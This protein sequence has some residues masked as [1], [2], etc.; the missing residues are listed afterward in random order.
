V[1]A[2]AIIGMT[3]RFPA[4]PDLH[5]FWQNLREG[6]E[7]ISFFRSDEL[8][9][10][11]VDPDQ[12]TLPGFV[13][14]AGILEGIDL[15]DA[16][17][18]GFNPRDADMLDPQHR[19]FLECA[20]ESLEDAGCDPNRYDGLIGVFAGGSASSYATHLRDLRHE[21]AAD[22][23][24]IILGNDTAFLAT[25][26]AYKLNLRGP[27]VTVQSACSTSLVAVTLA[28]HSLLD[29]QCD[30]A[31]AGGVTIKVPHKRGYIYQEGGIS[32]PDGH[33]RAF[34]KQAQG[35]VGGNGVG[36]VVLK[37]LS[38][39]LA[40]RDAIR[41]VILGAAI[42][43]D[44]SRKVSFA[45]PSIDGQARV[46]A[47]AQA[48]AGVQPETISY[49]E[50][51]GTGTRLGDPIEI[52][53]LAHA[54]RGVGPGKT[55]AIGSVKTN[56]GH[57]DCAAGVAGLIKTVLAL[58][59]EQI[60]PSLHFRE[61]NPE[62]GF[63]ATPFFVNSN[64]RPWPRSTR[65]RRAG[66]NSFGVGGTNAHVLVEEAP[67]PREPSPPGRP[68]QLLTFSAQTPTALDEMTSRLAKHLRTVRD[69][70]LADIAYSL[71]VGRKW[72][73]HRRFVVC[74][75]AADAAAA[76][77][78]RDGGCVVTATADD[79]TSSAVFLFS[80]QGA[81]H[82]G[83][84]RELY[85]DENAFRD[86][87]DRC[88]ELLQPRLGLDLRE[89]L[90]P[91]LS[92]R[93][94]DGN[95]KLLKTCLAQP[96]LFVVE[97]ALARLWQ[98]WGVV[99]C[100]MIG[101][102]IGEYAAACVAG[103]FRLEDALMLVA[104]RGRLMQACPAGAMTVVPLAEDKVLS[105][106]DGDLAL[107]A[108]NGSAL[109]VVSGPLDAVIGLERRVR[110]DGLVCRRL[111]TS[112]AFHS[113]MMEP[114]LAPFRAELSRVPLAAPQVPMLSNVTGNWLEPE[115]ATDPDYWVEQLRRTV[116]FSDGLRRVLA[117]SNAAL[118]E[119]GPGGTLASLARLSNSSEGPRLILNSL[120]HR[121]DTQPSGRLFWSTLGR[122]W[123]AGHPI[124]WAAVHAHERRHRVRL[125][126]YP[127][128]RERYWVDTPDGAA[129]APAA[130]VAGR[131]TKVADIA[132]WFYAPS[133]TRTPL[134]ER[135]RLR[136]LQGLDAHCLVLSDGRELGAA[137][138]DR[139]EAEPMS[140]T[141]VTAGA[142]F[143]HGGG[144]H[145]E[146]DPA[147]REDYF[148]LV[149]ALR[150]ERRLPN[151]IVHLWGLEPPSSSATED[152]CFN[153]AQ[154]RGFYSIVWL[155]QALAQ[156]RVDQ[157]IAIDVFVSGLYSVCDGDPLVPERAPV[158]AA[159]RGVSQ[160]YPHLLCRTIDLQR[161]GSHQSGVERAEVVEALLS[162]IIQPPV[163]GAIAYRGRTR[164]SRSYV[165]M[166][167]AGANDVAG[168]VRPGGVYLITG[169]LGKIGL[170]LAR[171]LAGAFAAKLVLVGP[172][173][174]RASALWGAQLATR[175]DPEEVAQRVRAI[176]EIEAAGGEVLVVT[177]DLGDPAQ[178]RMA[179]ERARQRF[180]TLNGIIHGA[181]LTRPIGIRMLQDLDRAVCEAHFHAK[182]HSVLALRAAIGP[183]E[184]DFWV[185]LSS[186][187]S[188][189]GGLG[190]IPYAAANAFLDA[191]AECQS[192]RSEEAWISIDWDGW[193]LGKSGH[194]NAPPARELTIT[195][196]E[197]VEAFRRILQR[198]PELPVVVSTGD[199]FARIEQWVSA[200]SRGEA[201]AA[202]QVLHVRPPI[203]TSYMAPRDAL[204]RE[205]VDVWQQLFGLCS[206]GINDSF[207][208]LGGH[209]LL[210]TTLV[211]RMR[212]KGLHTDIQALLDAPTPAGLAAHIM[213]ANKRATNDTAI[214]VRSTNTGSPLFFTNDG[215]GQVIYVQALAPYI[216]GDISIYVVPDE[217]PDK[218][219]LRT[220]E[221]LASRLVR[222]IEAVQPKGPYR[223][224]GYSFGGVLAFEAATQ[225][226]GRDQHVEFLGLIDSNLRIP[227]NARA[228][229]L[230]ADATGVDANEG[231]LNEGLLMYIRQTSID[232]TGYE[233]RI[234]ELAASARTMDLEA[235][236]KKAEELSLVPDWLT[237]ELWRSAGA[238]LRVINK[239]FCEYFPHPS[240]LAVHL[241]TADAEVGA[242]PLRGWQAV[243]P[244]S[245][246]RV[247]PVP[248][249]HESLVGPRNS[250]FLGRE[251]SRAI[252]QVTCDGEPFPQAGCSA[253]IPLRAGAA[254]ADALFCVPGG[255]ASS[256]TFVKLAS[257][258][259]TAWSIYG[260]EPRGL[261]GLEVPHSTVVAAAAAYL[262][263]V[264]KVQ[265]T[266][267]IHL[268]GH[269]F[270]GW[271]AFEMALRLQEAG[272]SL[273]SLTIVD[274]DVPSDA[275]AYMHEYTNKE[276][277][278]ELVKAME[279]VSERPLDIASGDIDNLDGIE[280]LR[281]LHDR[282]IT[283]GLLPPQ[284]D[285]KLLRG[286]FR[287]FATC[288]RTT[289]QPSQTYSQAV[290]LVAVKDPRIDGTANQR[291]QV[292]MADGW[293][294]WAP[295]LI[296]SLGSGNHMTVLN[297][298][299]VDLLATYV[300]RGAGPDQG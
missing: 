293:R 94:P 70:E 36:V 157:T 86:E 248:G 72:L 182:V 161:Q 154:E 53:S 18:F 277:F 61:A 11:G 58:E 122:L 160:E 287:T 135:R 133:W 128:E 42:N 174:L 208:Q 90:Y 239:M 30:M 88:A 22:E 219:E 170:L 156:E 212:Q 109:C 260:L 298:P 257:S 97:Y 144:A 232:E 166:P 251:L 185:L 130:L 73:P 192:K 9:A 230:N 139:L 68:W 76:L 266:G 66:V 162:E 258:L 217:P 215:A 131:D 21:D 224:G 252:Q 235:F 8:V 95:D 197:G 272:R 243:L 106:L 299:H 17:L 14:A 145:F 294:R 137:L 116:R 34:D 164:W 226:L 245:S 71:H 204:E 96:A 159:C 148:S 55:C 67:P 274:S 104:A 6:I 211:E 59:H 110:A 132:S 127:F 143:R 33:C 112:H 134:P 149:A 99:P 210:A 191:F 153:K 150:S 189:L 23:S 140:V 77:D 78:S 169:G 196:R 126:T 270:G 107:A 56:I 246:I 124:D 64:L 100:A 206:V 285:P 223:L 105:L 80:G 278:L 84:G 205:I 288:L 300:A 281:I 13:P 286:P 198:R 262:R 271:V 244:E 37:R 163:R 207:F 261:D 200:G 229:Y 193:D 165:R 87:V 69:D 43:N 295:R 98:S 201:T 176:R 275:S 29:Y 183:Q 20:W 25:R 5:R 199:L 237:A 267:R 49:I 26:V 79:R 209:S 265:P 24:N 28:C 91:E 138:V 177:A 114:A 203:Q 113:P 85:R 276:A 15:F 141:L 202:P 231:L 264:W 181:G 62:I 242:D 186:I 142:T 259:R 3:G 57:L 220:I 190:L 172:T 173:P 188:V 296:C 152:G 221:G 119:I 115:S 158:D 46:I 12:V 136:H 292:Q 234:S 117:D 63:D 290:R 249:T 179:V 1:E 123:L 171:H 151:R 218:A 284:S 27:S 269:S 39:A 32:S 44:G 194:S 81:Q 236:V 253:L 75:R 255:G 256:S 47:T 48:F 273:T 254:G 228:R 54:F 187:S 241:F 214:C 38:D 89:A 291:R 222:M 227:K 10:A 103:V 213:R 31:L 41:A 279:L 250:G 180:G 52:A 129:G 101:H 7:C 118:L 45:A 40:D 50:A 283:V 111:Q 83:M 82:A 74:Q 280:R 35:T 147:S 168:L 247:T 121:D 289:Y 51:H 195:P 240:F 93:L 92:D 2:I 120:P 175:N 225:L 16:R 178:A 297:A 60:P 263:D 65:P 184:V 268:L 108:V 238:R 233:D 282:L 19:L 125:P 216:E 155:T 102:S 146:I 4:A 167:L